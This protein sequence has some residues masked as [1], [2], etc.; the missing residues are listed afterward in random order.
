MET[1]EALCS[2]CHKPASAVGALIKSPTGYDEVYICSE[3][4]RVC[5][6]ILD[7]GGF[8]RLG[9]TKDTVE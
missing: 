1:N 5:A 4:I 9:I 2:F 8:E 6:T 3:C 7:D